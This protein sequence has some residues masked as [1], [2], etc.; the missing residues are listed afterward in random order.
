MET[1]EA[2]NQD[3]DFSF[4]AYEEIASELDKILESGLGCDYL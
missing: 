2:R 1:A 4:L 3:A